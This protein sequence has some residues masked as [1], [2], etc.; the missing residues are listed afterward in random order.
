MLTRSPL[1]HDLSWG[2]V[3]VQGFPTFKDVVLYPG[4][5]RVWDWRE[6]GTRHVPGIQP[7]DIEVLLTSGVEVVILSRGMD[8][9][10][11]TCPETLALLD[12]RGVMT[13]VLQSQEAIA[14]Y[15]RLRRS[16][17]VG[18]LIHSTC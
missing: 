8:L 14:L 10:L 11:Q 13:H 2:R 17:R 9:R 3:E 1:V 6:T 12:A 4:G 16:E 15:N 5:A 7:A 18:A